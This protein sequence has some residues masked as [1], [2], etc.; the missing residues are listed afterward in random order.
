[1][2]EE[3]SITSRIQSFIRYFHESYTWLEN[4]TDVKATKWRDLDR[5]KTK[6]A[7]AE[8]IEAMCRVW[9]EF[10]YWFA[11]GSDASPRG[12]FDPFEYF[13]PIHGRVGALEWG[14]RK[15]WRDEAGLLQPA[16]GNVNVV[17]R[18][19]KEYEV[20]VAER[21][22][23]FSGFANKVDAETLAETFWSEC[24]KPIQ[25]GKNIYLSE[26]QIKDWINRFPAHKEIESEEEN[27]PDSKNIKLYNA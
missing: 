12:Q 26:K 27:S 10:A 19:S 13:G 11:T 15:L 25:P 16:L 6:A 5:G 4:V 24:L 18:E 7:T 9:P 2:S 22:L 14:V 21:I 20:S 17:G 8:M 23:H 1:M 3:S